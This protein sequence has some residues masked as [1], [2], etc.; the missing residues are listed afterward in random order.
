MR[1][2]SIFSLLSSSG[3]AA[4]IPMTTFDGYSLPTVYSRGLETRAGQAVKKW[5]AMGDSYA[6]GIG[7]GVRGIN[8]GDTTCSRYTES[9]PN[10]MN[11]V[12]DGTGPINRQF[13]DNACSGAVS[14][15]QSLSSR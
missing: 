13:Q 8:N 1:A 14:T 7:A 2:S 5:A 3:L 4:S 11:V 12:L 9:Y 10:V 6:S 15:G